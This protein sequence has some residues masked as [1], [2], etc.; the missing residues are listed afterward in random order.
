MQRRALTPAQR[1]STSSLGTGLRLG[2]VHRRQKV[3]SKSLS[4]SQL[5]CW[6]LGLSTMGACCC[7]VETFTSTFTQ[8]KSGCTQ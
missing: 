1:W 2:H 3:G 5:Q 7:P 8:A 6:L 4:H